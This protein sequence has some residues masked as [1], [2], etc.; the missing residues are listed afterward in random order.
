MA[1]IFIY[2][3]EDIYYI[4]TYLEKKTQFIVYFE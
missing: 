2:I 3:Y 4:Y 1:S